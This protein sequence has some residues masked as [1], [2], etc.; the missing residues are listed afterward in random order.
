MARNGR[1]KPLQFVAALV[2]IGMRELLAAGLAEEAK[3]REVMRQIAFSLCDRYART[4]MYI[5]ADLE[6]ELTQRDQEIW[7]EYGESSP[8]AHKYS[9]ARVAELANKHHLTTVQIYAVVAR[10]RK[11]ELKA[12]Q[13]Q[14]PGFDPAP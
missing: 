14:L 7:R 13:G 6:F 3:A 12:R 4:V 1:E 2:E 5:P 10:M 9:P 11:I 8:T